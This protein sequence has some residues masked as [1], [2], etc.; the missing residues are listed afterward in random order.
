MHKARGNEVEGSDHPCRISSFCLF[1]SPDFYTLNREREAKKHAYT[2]KKIEDMKNG[3]ESADVSGTFVA[4][5]Q[6]I[7]KRKKTEAEAELPSKC[8]IYYSLSTCFSIFSQNR[9]SSVS[10]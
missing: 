5:A 7:R 2:N 4:L 10:L 6:Q 9:F 8:I 3:K 1:Y